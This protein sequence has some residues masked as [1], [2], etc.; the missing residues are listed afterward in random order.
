[1]DDETYVKMDFKTLP[2]PQYYTKS[3]DENLP[4]VE[5]TVGIEKF[6]KKIL[7]WQAIC[8]CGLRSR[9]FLT[10]VTINKE[11]YTNECLKKRLLPFIASHSGP[12]IFWPDLASAH[13]AKTTL[14]W[15][16]T[17]NI[18]TVP[19]EAN[20]PN[21]P[22]LRPIER[23]WALVK[24]ELKNVKKVAQNEKD[25]KQKWDS[26]SK[27]VTKQVIINIMSN[28]TTKVKIFSKS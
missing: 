18:Y 16:E 7:V 20:P 11:I 24:K 9:T 19:K 3:V 10:N 13:Y 23:Y 15:L 25:F 6:G 17:N 1:M 12:V 28:I 4:L 2:G 27:K 26:S 5:T 8:Q 21:V 22:E 14:E